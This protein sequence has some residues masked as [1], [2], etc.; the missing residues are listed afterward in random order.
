MA[1][2]LYSF[3]VL[4]NATTPREQLAFPDKF[5]TASLAKRMK[6]AIGS[7]GPAQATDLLRQRMLQMTSSERRGL[8]IDRSAKNIANRPEWY[9]DLA[10]ALGIVHARADKITAATLGAL[11]DGLARLDGGEMA[12]LLQERWLFPNGYVIMDLWRLHALLSEIEDPALPGPATARLELFVEAIHPDASIPASGDERQIVELA[13]RLLGFLRYGGVLESQLAGTDVI[14]PLTIPF[15][16]A[17]T[18]RKP[19]T[20]TLHILTSSEAAAPY[21]EGIAEQSTAW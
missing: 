5:G 17:L 7:A 4:D 10:R 11:S 3:K 13:V 20:A 8:L 15:R 16:V 12:S 2:Y 18:D 1:S 14:E 19:K 21:P 9:A 6:V